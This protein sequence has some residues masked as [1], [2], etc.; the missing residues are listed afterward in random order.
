MLYLMH[1]YL[2]CVC[3]C[4]WLGFT[5]V[6]QLIMIIYLWDWPLTS[7]SARRDPVPKRGPSEPVCRRFFVISDLLQIN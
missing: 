7:P 3:V 1:H 4:V 6:Y 5:D 2:E